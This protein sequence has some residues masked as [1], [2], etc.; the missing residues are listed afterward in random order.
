MTQLVPQTLGT[1]D[2]DSQYSYSYTQRTSLASE[3]QVTKAWKN[4][5]SRP[6]TGP[7]KFFFEG[8][9]HFNA[10]CLFHTYSMYD[11]YPTAYF[12][13]LS[14]MHLFFVI[15]D[16][17][18]KKTW[19]ISR[20]GVHSCTLRHWRAR[21]NQTASANY[22]AKLLSNGRLIYGITGV[23]IQ[24]KLLKM[25][26]LGSAKTVRE[27]RFSAYLI[28]VIIEARASDN[29]YMYVRFKQQFGLLVF[30]LKMHSL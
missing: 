24:L 29:I 20:S 15:Q 21:I 18:R 28:R 5:Y 25:N 2:I 13:T 7:L 30:S 17:L 3:K 12:I 10:I 1:F 6:L 11:I 22:G 26:T 23:N 19:T 14:G 16:T 4:Y 8:L 27:N 9:N